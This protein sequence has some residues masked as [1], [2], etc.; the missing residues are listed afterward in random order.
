[1]YPLG[2]KGNNIP[3]VI[4]HRV[5][6]TLF[7]ASRIRN[8]AMIDTRLLGQPDG[9]RYTASVWVPALTPE[10]KRGGR[11]GAVIVKEARG[12]FGVGYAGYLH[13]S[14]QHPWEVA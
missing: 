1:V 5:F 9:Y 8:F 3:G 10:W 11:G 4:V 2:L 12:T 7:L 6:A 13:D 14:D